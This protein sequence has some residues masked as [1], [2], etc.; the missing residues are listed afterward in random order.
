[1]TGRPA[2]LDLV[3]KATGESSRDREETRDKPAYK[4]SPKKSTKSIRKK[5]SPKTKY[6]KKADTSRKDAATKNIISTAASKLTDV[7]K[8][9]ANEQKPGGTLL[10]DVKPKKE[11]TDAAQVQYRPGVSMAQPEKKKKP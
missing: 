9:I 4:S 7:K 3:D 10:V 5:V 1:M 6:T 11:S 8:K 2:I